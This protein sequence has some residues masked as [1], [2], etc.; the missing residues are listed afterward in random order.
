MTA[1]LVEDHAAEAVF[2]GN[3][4]RSCRTVVRIYHGNGLVCGLEAD[5]PGLQGVKHLKAHPPTLVTAAGL[6]LSI[7]FRNGGD[8][9]PVYLQVQ[10][11]YA[12][13]GEEA[14]RAAHEEWSSNIFESSVLADL[15]SPADFEAAAQFVRPDDMHDSL[16]ISSDINEHADRI[17]ELAQVGFDAIFLHD[18]H[19]D[20]ESFID[21]FSQ[22]LPDLARL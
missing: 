6:G 19:R 12:P 18:V 20:Q 8:G 14:L 9:K 21:G 7:L 1:G 15:R 3:G 22:I 10:L 17:S 13:T 2:D 5:I 4:H 11:S 16:I